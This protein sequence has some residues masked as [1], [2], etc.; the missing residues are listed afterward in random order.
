MLVRLVFHLNIRLALSA[1]VIVS[2]PIEPEAFH[3]PPLP[4]L[5]GPMEQNFRL[6]KVEKLF[7]GELFGPESMSM[8]SINRIYLGLS[9]GTI[10]RSIQSLPKDSFSFE[11][12]VHLGKR[13]DGCG[14]VDFELECGRPLGHR[15]VPSSALNLFREILKTPQA[16]DVLIVASSHQGI[17]AVTLEDGQPPQLHPLVSSFNGSSF[18]FVNDVVITSNGTV[19]FTQSSRKWLR[20]VH[21]YDI[22]ERQP[23]GSLF[24]FDPKRNVTE[25]LI[26]ELYFANGIELS[27]KEDFLLFAETSSVRVKRL[28]LT[29]PCPL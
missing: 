18:T 15:F 25:E 9:N 20:S 5:E 8:D 22:L 13:R 29:G 28:W 4:K 19:F 21:M 26:S 6:A 16:S 1:L 27:P 17:Q 12:V 11:E 14:S 24:R 2:S 7:D 10:L 23:L 3:L